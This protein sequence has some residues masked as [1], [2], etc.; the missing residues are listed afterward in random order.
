MYS[1]IVCLYVNFSDLKRLPGDKEYCEE[2]RTKFPYE[3]D[4]WFIDIIDIAVFDFLLSHSDAKHVYVKDLQ[5]DQVLFNLMFD[6][7]RAWVYL[8][9]Y[10]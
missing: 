2:F 4:D 6:F 9:V 3:D 8:L 1:I 10:P 5:T 7:G